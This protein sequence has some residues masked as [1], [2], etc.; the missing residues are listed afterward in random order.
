MD[1]QYMTARDKLAQ[2]YL[3][4]MFIKVFTVLVVTVISLSCIII[5]EMKLLTS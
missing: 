2:S 4:P 1:V 3:F 5:W